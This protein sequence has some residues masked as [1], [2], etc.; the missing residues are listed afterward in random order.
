[1]E[2]GKGEGGHDTKLRRTPAGDAIVLQAW[3]QYR[4]TTGRRSVRRFHREETVAG[5]Y[6]LRSVQRILY[7][8]VAAMQAVPEDPSLEPFVDPWG[9]DWP[10]DPVGIGVGLALIRVGRLQVPTNPENAFAWFRPTKRDL[11]WAIKLSAPFPIHGYQLA[12]VIAARHLWIMARLYAKRERFYK[13]N[14][15]NNGYEDIDLIYSYMT[16]H[17]TWESGENLFAFAKNLETLEAG[18]LVGSIALD[19]LYELSFMWEESAWNK[20]FKE[21]FVREG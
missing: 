20:F 6:S 17:K 10:I 4:P 18:K 9:K 13:A 12:G 15:L 3:Q 14:G 7:G 21:R 11:A 5:Q 16:F 19:Y 2:L 1:M 8:P